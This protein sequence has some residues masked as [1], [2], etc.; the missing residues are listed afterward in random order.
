MQ[1]TRQLFIL[2]NHDSCMSM[3]WNAMCAICKTTKLKVCICFQGINI[4][5]I[6]MLTRILR[7]FFGGTF[8]G[9]YQCE[10]VNRIRY[11]LSTCATA[12]GVKTSVTGGSQHYGGR[13]YCYESGYTWSYTISYWKRWSGVRS[14]NGIVGATP[15]SVFQGLI[16]A[17]VAVPRMKCTKSVAS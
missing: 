2:I 14:M 7:V 4:E 9:S 10:V 1:C 17:P 12:L 15:G 16:T 5:R 13:V 3:V 8:R 6:V 11:S